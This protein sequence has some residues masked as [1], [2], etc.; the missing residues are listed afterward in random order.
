MRIIAAAGLLALGMMAGQSARAD[1]LPVPPFKGNDT[2]G[3]IAYSMAN[4]VDARQVAVDHCARY[5][6]VVKFLGVQAYEGGY[7][8]FSCR[9]VPYGAA[10]QPIRTLY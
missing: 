1:I 4:Q 7:I 9:W 8:S 5:G 10:N 3:I 2:G 6:K